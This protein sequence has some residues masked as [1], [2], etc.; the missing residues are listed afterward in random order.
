MTKK[1]FKRLLI[2]GHFQPSCFV[3]KN[4]LYDGKFI[5]QLPEKEIKLEWIVISKEEHELYDYYEYKYSKVENR[6]SKLFIYL[7]LLWMLNIIS[8][9]YI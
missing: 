1:V 2:I 7:L 5:I 9:I 4:T 8:L 6:K 3:E